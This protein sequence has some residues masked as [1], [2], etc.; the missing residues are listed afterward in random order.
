MPVKVD[1]AKCTGCGDCVDVCPVEILEVKD[2]KVQVKDMDECTDCGA[3]E[4]ACND[5]AIKVED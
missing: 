1:N 3:C 4:D 2:G 5:N